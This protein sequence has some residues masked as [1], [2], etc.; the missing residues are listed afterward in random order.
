MERAPLPRKLDSVTGLRCPAALVVFLAHAYGLIP[1]GRV[2][3]AA[4]RVSVPGVVAVSF[5]FMISGFVLTWTHRDGD[6]PR[7]FYQR[8]FARI[9]PVYW[10]T[11]VITLPV[12]IAVSPDGLGETLLHALPS[13][14]GIQTW[15][16]DHKVFYGGNSPGWSISVEVFFYA[17]FPLLM[18]LP[19]RVW[20]ARWWWAVL[21]AL[22]LLIPLTIRLSGPSSDT[23]HALQ[24]VY[25]VLRLPEFVAGIVLAHHVRAGRRVPVGLRTASLITL[26]AYLVAGWLPSWLVIDVV[27][28]VPFC[29]LTTAA[30]V[31]D[32]EGSPSWFRGRYAVRM[33]QWSLAFYLLHLAVNTV[34]SVGNDVLPDTVAVGLLSMVVAFL[35]SLVLAG[36][37]SH[38]YEAP[39]EARLRGA[40]P[41]PE[42]PAPA[43][44]AAPSR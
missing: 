4:A 30:A 25:P 38:Y 2:R 29:L 9:A 39:L 18:L 20:C 13:V 37:V 14:I 42:A 22:V 43:G 5:F 24:H 21:P 31:A 40:R 32:L 33:G 36:L 1:E 41:R 10:L 23:T 28:F 12:F 11:L 19:A 34:I 27:T 16:P 35:T 8:R 3:D 17:L 6:R 44:P 15:F 7:A 26:A